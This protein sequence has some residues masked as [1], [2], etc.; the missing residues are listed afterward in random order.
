M[1]TDLFTAEM[2]EADIAV[3]AE[4]ECWMCE[5]EVSKIVQLR[6]G[7]LSVE[8]CSKKKTEGA[9]CASFLPEWSKV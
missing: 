6:K 4:L 2:L 7:N 1:I 9:V 5:Q 8:V 3:N